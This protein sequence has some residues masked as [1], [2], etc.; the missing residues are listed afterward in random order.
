MESIIC[1]N[2]P[3]GAALTMA[4]R[5]MVETAFGAV[6]TDIRPSPS[7]RLC[8]CT[9]TVSSCWARLVSLEVGVLDGLDGPLRVA[10]SLVCGLV[11]WPEVSW[12]EATPAAIQNTT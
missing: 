4:S 1:T 9:V 2:V 12:A 5:E 7:D 10:G 11:A 8:A 3:P 6:C